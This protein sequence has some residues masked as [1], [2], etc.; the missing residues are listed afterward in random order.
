[1]ALSMVGTACAV[2]KQLYC[3]PVLKIIFKHKDIDFSGGKPV[4]NWCLIFKLEGLKATSSAGIHQYDLRKK[5][6]LR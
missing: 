2:Q 4:Q 6:E 3:L 1:M 5:V